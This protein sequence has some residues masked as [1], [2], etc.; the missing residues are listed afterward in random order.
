ME[1]LFCPVCRT[2]LV[3]THRG[4]YEDLAEHVSDPN[5]TPSMKDGYQCTNVDWCEASY[6]N[7]TWISDGDCFSDPPEG[8]SF[9]EASSRLKKSS[10]SGMEF[11]LNSWNHYYN[12]GKEKIKERRIEFNIGKFRI[13]V[14][15]K[16]KGHRYPLNKQYMP[17]T[18]RWRYEIW[19][20]SE[21]SPGCYTSIILLHR[22]V[23]HSLRSFRMS[24]RSAIHNPKANKNSIKECVQYIDGVRWGRIDDRLFVKVSSFLIKIL[25]P[26]KCRTIRKM[27][28]EI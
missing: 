1:D 17:S 10:V 18:F 26:G 27:V 9:S 25:Y 12:Y 4:R 24:Y 8:V 23:L 13:A 21:D 6:L 14:E 5:G 3:I 16:E 22:M 2:K 7:F 28:K 11:A 19:K 20:K 15:P